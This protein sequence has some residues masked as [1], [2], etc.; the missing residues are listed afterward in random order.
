MTHTKTLEQLQEENKDLLEALKAVRDYEDDRP[1]LGT[2][3]YEIYQQIDKA[4]A[5]AEE[6]GA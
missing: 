2:R 4:I 6:R 5:K 3:G 1:A